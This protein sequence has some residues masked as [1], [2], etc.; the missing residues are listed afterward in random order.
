MFEIKLMVSGLR[1]QNRLLGELQQYLENRG[2][3]AA[4]D[5]LLYEARTENVA[6]N[7]KKLRQIQKEYLSGLSGTV[8]LQ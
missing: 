3:L 6:K 5:C 4:E 2:V 8:C 7:L 1:K